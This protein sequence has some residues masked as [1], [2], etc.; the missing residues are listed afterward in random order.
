MV[1][2]AAETILRRAI[3]PTARGADCLAIACG[4]IVAVGREE[5]VQRCRSE[6][7]RTIDL[8]GRAVLPGFVDA[9]TH[10]LTTGLKEIAWETDLCGLSRDETL[11]RL[12]TE[13]SA[14]GKDEWVVGRDWDESLWKDRR[15]LDRRE[16]DTASPANP[17]VAVRIDGHLLA[18]NTLALKRLPPAIRQTSAD[19]AHGLLWEEA[20]AAL[21]RTIQPD[22]DV[23]L[24]AL[25]AAATLAHR[26][27]ITSVHAMARPDEVPLYLR[28][29]GKG[30][31][32]VTLCPEAS[33]LEALA[34][35]GLR[36]GFGNEWLRLGGV[37]I[38]ADGSIG[39]RNAALRAP[40][41]NSRRRGTLTHTTDRLS[42]LLL[43]AEES[44]LQTLVHAIGDR[45]IEQV[46]LAHE[47]VGSAHELR[48]RI[49]HF[50]LAADDQ[51]DRARRLGLQISMQPNFV[52]AWSGEGKLYE[53][54]L[55]R[56]RDL[57][58]DRHRRILDCG[59]GLAFGSDSMPMSPLYGLHWAVNAPHP[60]QRVTVEEAISC[61]TE[62]G[63]YLSFEEKDKGRIEVG[64][65]ADLVVL[66]EDPRN[67]TDRIADLEVV[68]TFVGGERVYA[69]GGESCA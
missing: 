65:Q 54:R 24:Q 57:Q 9:H 12:S 1:G 67:A 13:A 19:A 45:A 23:R 62:A 22:D 64:C 6:S 28:E 37:K 60:D 40:Y 29:R 68:M 2:Q 56:E 44:R 36:S 34:T 18:A 50:E 5:D 47:S 26:Q 16:L 43:F 69:R 51:I 63:A 66:G 10:P 4:R 38:F 21:L 35:L 27:G 61:Y 7:T 42:S 11:A 33:G 32:R 52:G 8:G 46:L 53:A 20:V 48:H 14:R 25:R 17:L 58:I 41:A 30:R 31:L 3:I 55:G 59:L 15:Y 49:E 39:A